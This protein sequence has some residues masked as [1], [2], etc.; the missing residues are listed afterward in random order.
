MKSLII[1][2]VIASFFTF[3]ACQQN[4]GKKPENTQNEKS[5]PPGTHTVK[6]LES[7]NA[8]Q[9]T[10]IKVE[11]NGKEY[12]IAVQ[13]MP[14]QK[15]E[16]LYFTKSMEMKNFHSDALNKTFDSV[17]FVEDVSTSAPNKSQQLSSAHAKI[18]SIPEENISI[19]PLKDGKTVA[20]IFSE[21]NELNGKVVKVKGKV[22]KYNPSIMGRN[23]IH[24]QDGTKSGNEY[25]LMVTSQD[26]AKVGEIVVVTGTVAINKDFGAGYTYPVMLENATVKAE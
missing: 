19:K 1:L 2:L 23:W 26:Q 8:S 14:V 6:V 15:G 21:K 11:E 20:Q 7:Q 22:S 12:W 9:Y 5:L 24:I 3:N 17:L 25:D 13:Q 10:Y 16:T 4:A 18:S